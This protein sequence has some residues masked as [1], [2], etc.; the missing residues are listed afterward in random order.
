MVKTTAQPATVVGSIDGVYDHKI[1]GWALSVGHLAHSTDLELVFSGGV[2]RRFTT[3][4]CRADVANL[5]YPADNQ[6]GFAFPISALTREEVTTILTTTEED[7]V[8]CAVSADH[9]LLDN[10]PCLISRQQLIDSVLMASQPPVLQAAIDEVTQAAVCGWC[11]EAGGDV[12]LTVALRIDGRVVCV[13]RADAPRPD[14]ALTLGHDISRC[15]FDMPIPA[16]WFDGSNHTVTVED[17]LHRRLLGPP[18][19][20]VFPAP[21]MVATRPDLVDEL[22]Q[23]LAHGTA[24]LKRFERESHAVAADIRSWDHVFR[25]WHRTPAVTLRH[26]RREQSGF[27][28]RPLISIVMPVYNTTKW[29][30]IDAIESVCAQTYDNWELLI[31]DDASEDDGVRDLALRYAAADPGRIFALPSDINRG[32]SANTNRALDAARGE[33]I[34]FFDHDDLLE[35]DALFAVVQGLQHHRYRLIYTDEDSVSAEHVYQNPHFK[36]SW[37]P[38]LLAGLN[39]ICHFVVIE[40]GLVALAGPLDPA[41]DGAQDKEFLLRVSS[42]LTDGEVLHIPRVLYHWRQHPASFSKTGARHDA[43]SQRTREAALAWARARFGRV[44][45]DAAEPP[46]LYGVHLSAG[47]GEGEAPLVTVIIPTRD[48]ADLVADC[49]ASLLQGSYRNLEVLIVDHESEHKFSNAL[50]RILTTVSS[51]RIIRYRGAFNWS[52]INNHAAQR[53]RGE[54]LLFLNNDTVMISPDAIEQ[55]LAF[56]SLPDAGAVGARLLYGDGRTQ[57]VGVQLGAAGIAAHGFTGYDPEELVYFGYPKLTR[58]VAAVTGACLLVRRELFDAVGGFDVGQL[59]VALS[60]IDFCLK[61]LMQGRRNIIVSTAQFYH[62]ESVSRGS[63]ETPGNRERFAAESRAFRRRW[64]PL[65]DAD[66]FYNP[67]FELRGDPYRRLHMGVPPDY[68]F[69][70]HARAALEGLRDTGAAA[71]SE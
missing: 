13:Q 27:S 25:I 55:M 38:L 39:Y 40:T 21:T 29:M 11:I 53:A 52:A 3:H 14:V 28:Y 56:A 26:Q 32:I 59:G 22:R 1:C 12:P 37:D 17:V 9:V 4:Y 69:R 30:L 63:D 46:G 68:L 7:A 67:N 49:T 15:G 58:S 23:F 66:P 42:E 6:A 31:A 2:V 18:R 54:Y 24:L 48:R 61:L 60:D 71:E 19:A 50:F 62:H 16:A 35:P 43:V 36:P 70:Q 65:I 64:Q 8:A 10:S 33:Y 57:H 44:R 5:G 47:L 45:V 51:T 34:A 20:F 41:F